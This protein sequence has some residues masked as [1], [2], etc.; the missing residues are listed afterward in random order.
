[1]RVPHPGTN[2]NIWRYLKIYLKIYLTISQ[3]VSLKKVVFKHLVIL[4]FPSSSPAFAALCGRRRARVGAAERQITSDADAP[5]EAF[6]FADVDG[7]HLT[8]Q[9]PKD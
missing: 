4:Q 1:M 9:Q 6:V 7:F 2:T 3:D 5:L 8:W